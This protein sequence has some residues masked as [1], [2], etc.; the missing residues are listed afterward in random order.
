ME[1]RKY[2]KMK[3]II[4]GQFAGATGLSYVTIGLGTDG[5]VYRFDTGCQGWYPLPMS[6]VECSHRR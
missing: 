3:Q 6:V 4:V 5:V 2:I 1:K